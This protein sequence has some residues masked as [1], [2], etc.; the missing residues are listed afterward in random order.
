MCDVDV[1]YFKYTFYILLFRMTSLQTKFAQRDNR[2]E[3]VKLTGYITNNGSIDS[4]N[5]VPPQHPAYAAINLTKAQ[6]F[7]IDTRGLTLRTDP[8]TGIEYLLRIYIEPTT[9]PL[10]YQN[11]EWTMFIHLP[12]TSLN[13]IGI[14]IYSSKQEAESVN[15]NFLFQLS[16]QTPD[17]N[18][19]WPGK[20]AITMQVVD[21]NYF[22]KSVSPNLYYG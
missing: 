16:N 7:L 4:L 3:T 2:L 12:E 8:G 14:E 19:I 21:N 11:F 15:E 20:A 1:D 18:D 5:N 13:W 6:N 17:G 9:P 10:Y 22:L